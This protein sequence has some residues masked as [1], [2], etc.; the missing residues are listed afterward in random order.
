[1]EIE[2]KVKLLIQ[3]LKSKGVQFEKG[4]TN[5]E[6]IAVETNFDFRFPPDLKILLCSALPVSREFVDWRSALLTKNYENEI[7]ERL[8]SPLEGMLFDIQYNEFWFEQW[9]EKPEDFGQQKEIAEEN[10][11]KYPKLIPNLF[12]SLHSKYTE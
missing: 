11:R 10:F 7:L 6:L 5:E 9:G 4:L 3:L 2:D 12:S 8:N 1:M